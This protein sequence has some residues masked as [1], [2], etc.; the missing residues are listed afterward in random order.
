M[1]PILKQAKY[2]DEYKIWIEFEDGISG[3]IDLKKE[4]FGQIFEPLK[5]INYFKTFNLHPELKTITW[6]NGADFS[7]EFLYSLAIKG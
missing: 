3:E 4:I 6:P 1:F 7:P 2:L 5:D